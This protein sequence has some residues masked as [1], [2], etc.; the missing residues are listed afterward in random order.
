MTVN[1]DEQSYHLAVEIYALLVQKAA[2]LR[3]EGATDAFVNFIQREA[4]AQVLAEVGDATGATKEE[5]IRIFSEHY[6]HLQANPA[7]SLRHHGEPPE[8]EEDLPAD[9]VA[10]A[11]PFS[12]N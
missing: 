1:V 5:S 4:A 3:Q 12:Q 9:Y 2:W 7:L 11:N 10:P 6:C 8:P